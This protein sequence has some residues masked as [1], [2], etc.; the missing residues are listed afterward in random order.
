M[1]TFRRLATRTLLWGCESIHIKSV[2]ILSQVRKDFLLSSAS[3]AF[4]LGDELK[5]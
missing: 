5:G 2:K 3:H 4:P 1:E